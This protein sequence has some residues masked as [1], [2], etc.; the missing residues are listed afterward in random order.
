MKPPPWLGELLRVL[1][2]GV[3]LGV[4]LFVGY[5]AVSVLH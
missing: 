4:A 3:L 2:L 1:A 5:L